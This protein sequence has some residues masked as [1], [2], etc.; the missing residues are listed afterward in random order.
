MTDNRHMNV[1]AQRQIITQIGCIRSLVFFS[2]LA[3]NDIINYI[4]SSL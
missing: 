1:A 3:S 4:E 2:L